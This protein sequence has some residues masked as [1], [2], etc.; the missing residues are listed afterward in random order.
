[1]ESKISMDNSTHT[2]TSFMQMIMYKIKGLIP[3]LIGI[4]IGATA[5]FIYYKTVGC[6]TGSCPITSTPWLSI[7]WGS[8]MGYLLGSMFNKKNKK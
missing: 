2:K 1:M 8:V 4:V 3:E 5:G 7:I 6:S